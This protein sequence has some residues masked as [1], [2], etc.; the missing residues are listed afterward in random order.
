MSDRRNFQ[1]M[2][3]MEEKSSLAQNRFLSKPIAINKSFAL[4]YSSRYPKV[5]GKKL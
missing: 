3:F 4:D 1:L 2:A 5:Y